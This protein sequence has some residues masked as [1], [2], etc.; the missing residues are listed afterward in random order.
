MSSSESLVMHSKNTLSLPFL[1]DLLLLVTLLII[2]SVATIIL[3]D[4]YISG[5]VGD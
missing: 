4:M 1:L 3:V 5:E 2:S